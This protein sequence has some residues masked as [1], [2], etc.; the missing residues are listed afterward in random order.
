MHINKIDELID[1]VIDDFA[2][3]LGENDVVKK[4]ML[5]NN[6]VGYQDEINKLLIS[7]EKN[8][9]AEEINKIVSTDDGLQAATEI[10]K[11]YTSYYL[12][13]LL[14]V[15]YSGTKGQFINNMLEFTKLQANHNFKVQN[16]FNSESNSIVIKFVNI[17]KSL[18]LV[19]ELDQHKLE[20]YEKNDNYKSGITFLKGLDNNIANSLKLENLENNKEWQIHGLIK[21]IILL[22]LYFATDK[23]ELY[24]IVEQ[25]QKIGEYIYI[26]IVVPKKDFIDFGAIESMLTQKQNEKGL[27]NKFYELLSDADDKGR[28]LTSD[29]KIIQMVNKKLL[30]PISDDILLYHKDT[31]KYEKFTTIQKNKYKDD[32][33]LKFIVSKIDSVSDYYSESVSKMPE[34]KKNIEKLFYAPLANRK[35]T[36]VN[37]MEEIQIINKFH[38]QGTVSAEN[39]DLLSELNIYRQYPYINFKNFDKVGFTINPNKTIDIVRG[40]NFTEENEKRIIEMRTGSQLPV[41][42]IGFILNAKNIVE[43]MLPK[44]IKDIR[45]SKYAESGNAYDATYKYMIDKILSD[46]VDDNTFYWFFDLDKDTVFIDKYEQVKKLSPQESAKIIVSHLHDDLLKVIYNKIIDVIDKV[47]DISQYSFYKLA[48]FYMKKYIPLNSNDVR[49]QNILA[50]VIYE[51]YSKGNTG[52]DLSEDLFPGLDKKAIKLP[53]NKNKIISKSATLKVNLIKEQEEKDKSVYQ[54]IIKYG[55]ICQHII[56][57]DLINKNSKENESKFAE[58][59]LEFM[60]KY[61]TENDDRDFVCKSCGIQINL[62]KYELDGS[63]DEN[64]GYKSFSTPIK[65]TL[66]SIPEYDKYRQIIRNIDK[67]IDKLASIAS[68]YVLQEKTGKNKNQLKIKVIKDGIDLIVTHNKNMG[69]IYKKRSSKIRLDYGIT[70]SYLYIF[71]LDNEIFK[72]SSKDKDT[73]KVVKRNNI[74]IYILFLSVLEITDAQILYMTGDKLCNYGS[75]EKFG[76]RLLKD[77]KIITNNKKVTKNVTDYPVFSY[78]LFY[79]S[80]AIAKYNI[81]QI[82]D[83]SEVNKKFNPEIQK[84]VLHTLIDI[85]N[86]ILEVYCDN[87]QKG[88]IQENQFNTDKSGS[89]LHYLYD[90]LSTR[91]FQKL[92]NTYSNEEIHEKIRNQYYSKQQIVSEK[93]RYSTVKMES[94]PLQV[95]EKGPLAYMGYY[96]FNRCTASKKIFDRKEYVDNNM[97]RINKFTNCET[98]AFH[99]W[100][101]KRVCKLCNKDYKTILQSDN[102]Y[103][104]EKE[105]TQIKLVEKSKIYCVAGTKHKLIYDHV[106]KM[107]VCTICDYK[108]GVPVSSQKLEELDKNLRN[109]KRIA[110]EKNLVFSDETVEYNH[111]LIDSIRESYEKTPN[112]VEK[113]IEK[114]ESHTSKNVQINGN[115]MYIND[116]VY[117]IDHDY[118]GFHIDT[119]I[120][121]KDSDQKILIKKNHQ[122]YKKDVL[123]YIDK[124]QGVEVYY[125][126]ITYLLLGFKEK[127]KDYDEPKQKGAYIKVNYSVLN[128]L[129]YLGYDSKYISIEDLKNK[130]NTEF[131]YV[132]NKDERDKK[133]VDNI[134]KMI[135]KNRITNLKKTITDVQKFIYRIKYNYEAIVDPNE[136]YDTSFINRYKN[137]LTT[138]KVKNDKNKFFDDWETM[139]YNIFFKDLSNKTINVDLEENYFNVDD[140]INYDSSGNMILYYIVDEMAKLIDINEQSFTKNLI[141]FVIIDIIDVLHGIFNKEYEFKTFDLKKFKYMLQSNMIVDDVKDDYETE[142]IYGE[143][144]IETK[145][146]TDEDIDESLYSD[147]EEAD[148]LDIDGEL[149]YEVDYSAGVDYST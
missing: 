86:S 120:I 104:T 43:C 3:F 134:V 142:G 77:L 14:G 123:Y 129:K 144:K 87:H 19:V 91:F 30:I 66:E 73:Y 139:K 108:D 56:T 140:I 145:G 114:L 149:D 100:D 50:K 7:Y 143:Q 9:D 16:F 89:K 115:N 68:I 32:T 127:N 93:S 112:F 138:L 10:I 148:A 23:I 105:F 5:D 39:S 4:I 130:F 132:K 131:M 33:K 61:V 58:R 41:N 57:W 118:N 42:I 48:E 107:T 78:I 29:E 113:F 83:A 31:E 106:Q 36:L 141:T 72:S 13:C 102:K 128:K 88:G 82:K 2:K 124:S 52:Y 40:T 21:L 117:I 85:I 121:I 79:V 38:N 46:V 110:K 84:I 74:L 71:E 59:F 15:T 54:E 136:L 67:F 20:Q 55:A 70:D 11:K 62:K 60:Y 116:D 1:A 92:G 8:I 98:G 44:D 126:N 51:K 103:G 69:D 12:F 125:D 95:D 17:I 135:S 24:N 34:V 53:I 22:E 122:Y 80:C 25:S 133:V 81:F 6:F 97:Y 90:M 96:H 35:A 37:N 64:G 76:T 94:I 109:S 27:A 65:N 137:K 28:E 146:E 99:D 49:F 119:P 101:S 26:D 147:A 75:F 111:K 47:S 45:S 18:A 63:F